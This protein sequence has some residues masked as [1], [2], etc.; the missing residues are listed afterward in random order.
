M[1]KRS[2]LKAYHRYSSVYDSLFDTVFAE[3]RRL[4][5]E[6]VEGLS[7]KKILEVGVGTG[8]SLPAYS[9]DCEVWGI[10]ISAPML[11]RASDRVERLGLA[12]VKG[13]NIMDAEAMEFPDDS[14]DAVM[15][16]YVASVVGDPARMF[17]EVSRICKPGGDIMVVNHFTSSNWLLQALERCVAPLSRT[18]GFRPDYSIDE[19]MDDCRL[20]LASLRPVNWFGYWR[21]AHFRNQAAPALKAQAQPEHGFHSSLL[22]TD[23]ERA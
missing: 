21:L 22:N 5:I 11:Q 1:P 15:V 3:G 23:P 7:G 16:M 2:I 18:I 10:D 19:L 12:H 6:R 4:A 14:F 9:R 17:H 13:L 20:E 8:L